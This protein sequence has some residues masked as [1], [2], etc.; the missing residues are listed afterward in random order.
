MER[1]SGREIE[2]QREREETRRGE[3]RERNVARA[4]KIIIPLRSFRARGRGSCSACRRRRRRCR[5]RRL[6]VRAETIRARRDR[7]TRLIPVGGE[8]SRSRVVV[9]EQRAASRAE[10]RSGQETG[11]TLHPRV[12]DEI[13][14]PAGV[15]PPIPLSNSFSLSL[16]LSLFPSLRLALS[17]A[18][19]HRSLLSLFLSSSPLP[20]GKP[21]VSRAYN[22]LFIYVYIWR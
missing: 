4:K 2:R 19:R 21:S 20:P 16:P 15:V 1:K 3:R 12:D 10:S 13:R 5:R 17:R 8:S 14:S 11:V 9:G 6:R 18:R 7:A 22:K